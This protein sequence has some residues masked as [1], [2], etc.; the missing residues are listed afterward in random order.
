MGNLNDVSGKQVVRARLVPLSAIGAHLF[1]LIFIAACLYKGKSL[2]ASFFTYT[3]NMLLYALLGLS[4][5]SASIKWFSHSELDQPVT[6]PSHTNLYILINDVFYKSVQ[7]LNP[8]FFFGS[9]RQ[10][11]DIQKKNNIPVIVDGKQTQLRLLLGQRLFNPIYII[12][13]PL[14]IY[15]FFIYLYSQ[16]NRVWIDFTRVL[17]SDLG[18]SIYLILLLVLQLNISFDIFLTLFCAYTHYRRAQ[19]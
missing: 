15:I 16:H 12:G 8:F 4:Y 2:S 7:Y 1:F 5:L 6:N 17:G 18:A 14:Q 3:D 19:K 10:A 9:L 11:H 13:A